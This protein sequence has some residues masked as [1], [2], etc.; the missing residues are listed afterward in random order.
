MFLDI[1]L[2]IIK[3][4]FRLVKKKK[5][6][7]WSLFEE[8]KDVALDASFKA[9]AALI[10]MI[11]W[12]WSQWFVEALNRGS[13]ILCILHKDTYLDTWGVIHVFFGRDIQDSYLHQLPTWLLVFL[14]QFSS[15]ISIQNIFQIPNLWMRWDRISQEQ[16]LQ[17]IL[18]VFNVNQ[19][20]GGGVK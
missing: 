18:S 10:W 8:E 2:I 7:I 13:L 15:Q 14:F 9:S 3:N 17:Q 6:S 4:I 12:F 11:D 20:F 1:Y 19:K 5:D 16:S